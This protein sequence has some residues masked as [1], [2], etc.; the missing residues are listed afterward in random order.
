MPE[1]R[2]HLEHLNEKAALLRRLSS[3]HA[4]AD[5]PLIAAKLAEV[6]AEFEA[7][8]AVLERLP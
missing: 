4:A 3:E 5:N 1:N 6:A 8:A 2:N 7:R